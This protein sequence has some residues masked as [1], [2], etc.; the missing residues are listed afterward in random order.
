[1]DRVS[2][3]LYEVVMVR[4]RVNLGFG[5]GLGLQFDP[6]NLLTLTTK[7]NVPLL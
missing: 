3:R 2:F 6:N 4:V 5:S 1:M 7:G